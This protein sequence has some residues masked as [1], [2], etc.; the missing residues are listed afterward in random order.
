V[1]ATEERQVEAANPLFTIH[2]FKTIRRRIHRRRQL[3]MRT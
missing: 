2:P 3:A 1:D